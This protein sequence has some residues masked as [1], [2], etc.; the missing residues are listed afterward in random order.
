MKKLNLFLLFSLSATILAM[1]DKQWNVGEDPD[2]SVKRVRIV[3]A[4]LFTLMGAI[5][6]I[7]QVLPLSKSYIE[8]KVEE[9]RISLMSSP[10]P[11]SYKSYIEDDF[12]YYDPGLSYFQNL[13]TK[14]G[15]SNLGTAYSYDPATK[16]KKEIVIDKEYSEYM[17]LSIDSIGIESVRVTPNVESQDEEVYNEYLKNGLAHFKGTPLPGD[18][19]NSFIYGHSAIQSFF[20]NHQNLAETIFTR[21]EN[22]EV[23]D[24]VSIE[25]DG[26]IFKYKVKQ[27]K[28]V[29]PDDFSILASQGER[30]TVTLMTCWPLGI[31]SKRLIVVAERYE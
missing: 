5:I 14:A 11:D 22:I 12:A 3:I 8:G 2:K 20:S 13:A 16:Q 19:G 9:L 25:K 31:G 1:T 24:S 10:V 4:S 18:G 15:I 29:E 23:G 26:K 30:E 28:I 21:L 6:V 17:H 27:K 7:S